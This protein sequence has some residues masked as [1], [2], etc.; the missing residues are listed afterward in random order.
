MHTEIFEHNYELL[1]DRCENIFKELEEINQENELSE[2]DVCA[3]T[4][5][6]ETTGIYLDYK[7]KG[8]V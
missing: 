5:A 4:T 1:S 7:E 8:I 6:K 3:Y 2:F